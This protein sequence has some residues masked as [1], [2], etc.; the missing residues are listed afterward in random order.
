M[1]ELH[2]FEELLVDMAVVGCI[3]DDSDQVATLLRSLPTKYDPLVHAFRLSMVVVKKEA[4]IWVIKNESARLHT[5]HGKTGA[6]ALTSTAV[7]KKVSK[8]HIKCFNCGKNGHYK[9][10][11]RSPRNKMKQVTDLMPP[12]TP[13]LKTCG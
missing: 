2:K 5:N 7:K 6:I 13:K 1:K 8:A 3:P 12:W 4:A 9:N 11:C 10:E